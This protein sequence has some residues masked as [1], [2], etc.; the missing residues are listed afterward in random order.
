MKGP[1][2]LLVAIVGNTIHDANFDKTISPLNVWH[3]CG[4]YVLLPY[5]EILVNAE[6]VFSEG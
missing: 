1:S 4:R 5:L 3:F 2:V 6:W